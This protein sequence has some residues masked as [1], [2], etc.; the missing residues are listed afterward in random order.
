MLRTKKLLNFLDT[1][2]EHKTFLRM[3][4]V[5]LG[6]TIVSAAVMIWLMLFQ[7]YILLNSSLNFRCFIGAAPASQCV[8]HGITPGQQISVLGYLTLPGINPYIPLIYGIIGIA[9]AII[10][11]EG[12][13]GV[14]ARALKLPVKSTGLLFFLIVPIGAFVEVDEKMV[15][16]ARFRDSGRIM[17]GG[18]GTNVVVAL[19]ALALLLLLIGGLAPTQFNG[20]YVTS[21]ISPSPAENLFQQGHL[22]SGDLI[23]AVNGTAVHTPS[24]LSSYL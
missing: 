18:P 11:H 15:Q 23:L 5:F 6:I 20:V 7:T 17:A 24:D 2:A 21:V 9:V 12:M 3:G 14:I 13:H 1:L 4:W 22:H 10:V 8:A 19:V 16:K